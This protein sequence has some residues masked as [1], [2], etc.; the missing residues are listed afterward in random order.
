M[1]NGYFGQIQREAYIGEIHIRQDEQ[2]LEVFSF[3]ST[4][5]RSAGQHPG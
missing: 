4:Q 1:L 3:G 5:S 2:G